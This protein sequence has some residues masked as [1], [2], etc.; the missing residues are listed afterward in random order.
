[1]TRNELLTYIIDVSK[2]DNP[3]SWRLQEI[4]RVAIDALNDRSFTA[5]TNAAQ[6]VLSVWDGRD[7]NM[8]LEAIQQL[9]DA[10][11]KAA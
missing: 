2:S 1:M 3:P 11:T 9:R 10:L 5:L 6:D 8:Y 4:Q 7:M